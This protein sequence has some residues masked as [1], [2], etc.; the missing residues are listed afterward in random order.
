MVDMLAD[1][2]QDDGNNRLMGHCPSRFMPDM[3]G[4]RRIVTVGGIDR[5]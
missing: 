2:G 1:V 3:N 4:N 5:V